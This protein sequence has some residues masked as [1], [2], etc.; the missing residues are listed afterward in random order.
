MLYQQKV[1]WDPYGPL[2]GLISF[3]LFAFLFGLKMQPPFNAV[4]R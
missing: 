3:W 4:K 2:I 1:S